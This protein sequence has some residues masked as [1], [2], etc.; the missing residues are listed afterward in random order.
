MAKFNE[1]PSKATPKDND[2]LM[3]Y[4]AATKSNKL[5]P[6]SGVWNWIVGKLTNAV[7]S[8]LQ[9]NNKTVLGAIN[10]L[11]SNSSISLCRVVSGENTFSSAL[12]GISYEAI[13][14]YFYMPS[15]NPFSFNGG[16]FIAFQSSYLQENSMVVII[17]FGSS[18]TIENKTIAI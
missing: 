15:D 9:T 3:L 13:I 10:E 17:G 14:G 2:T 1:Y 18:G 8:N 5:S 6:F 12:K 7:I 11:N 16:Y 4:D